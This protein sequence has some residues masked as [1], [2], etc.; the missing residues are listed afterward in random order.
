MSKQ[1]LPDTYFYETPTCI[2]G[3]T[4][5][6]EGSFHGMMKPNKPNTINKIFEDLNVIKAMK[7]SSFLKEGED[8]AEAIKTEGVRIVSDISYQKQKDPTIASATGRI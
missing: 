6:F 7:L 4:E 1:D 8:I 2:N 5:K 3:Y